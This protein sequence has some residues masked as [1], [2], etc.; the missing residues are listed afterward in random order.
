MQNH[1]QAAVRTQ[2]RKQQM[3]K[4]SQ[5]YLCKLSVPIITPIGSIS[6]TNAKSI[7]LS[8]TLPL[9]YRPIH[10]SIGPLSCQPGSSNTPAP[11]WGHV[12]LLMYCFF[13]WMS[14]SYPY[15]PIQTKIKF[16]LPGTS[17]L[18]SP[19][20]INFTY[21]VHCLSI[22]NSYL[23]SSLVLSSLFLVSWAPNNSSSIT[24]PGLI[25]FKFKP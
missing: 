24:L 13:Q 4:G 9:N 19:S 3:Q 11:N 14:L 22:H 8:Q 12:L 20:P 7:L 25:T 1:K 17:S 16:I 15:G 10:L 21:S 5:W 23:S 6:M 18:N 2:A